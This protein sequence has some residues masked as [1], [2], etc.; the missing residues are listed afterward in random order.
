[1]EVYLYS[2][3]ETRTQTKMSVAR[4]LVITKYTM[5]LNEYFNMDINN[6]VYIIKLVKDDHNPKCWT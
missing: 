6:N 5:V 3:D 1:M 2:D 4:F